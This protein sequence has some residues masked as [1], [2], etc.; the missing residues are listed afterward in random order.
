MRNIHKS[1][2][3]YKNEPAGVWSFVLKCLYPPSVKGNDLRGEIER[4]L[5]KKKQ[6][7]SGFFCLC[8]SAVGNGFFE[9]CFFLFGKPGIHIGINCTEGNGIYGNM[10]GS[11]LLSKCLYKAVDASLC[12]RI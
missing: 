1:L 3:Y 4:R 12:E 11:K 2:Y 8:H 5:G 10:S 9:F 6:E 7:I